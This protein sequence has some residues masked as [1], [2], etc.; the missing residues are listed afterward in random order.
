VLRELSVTEL[1]YQA[2]LAV[3][4]GGLGVAEVAVSRR[5]PTASWARRP[6][7]SLGRLLHGCRLRECDRCQPR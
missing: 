5:E 2:V 6:V 4:E 7:M 1:R 3:T